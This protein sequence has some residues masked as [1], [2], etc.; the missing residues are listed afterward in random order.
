M[1]VE[2]FLKSIMKSIFVFNGC[3]NIVY[4]YGNEIDNNNFEFIR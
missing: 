1:F 4:A 3:V 2:V